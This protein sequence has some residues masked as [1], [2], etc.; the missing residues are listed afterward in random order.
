MAQ[1]DRVRI[2]DGSTWD[3]SVVVSVYS[4]RWEANGDLALDHFGAAQIARLGGVKGGTTGVI[5]GPSI[6]VH[7]TQLIGE[8]NTPNI[9]GLDLVHLFPIQLDHYMQVGWLPTH[10][11][12]VISGEPFRP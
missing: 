5:A 9:G 7:R 6:R 1:G 11:I 3:D 10:H 4:P 2:G 12:R 8:T